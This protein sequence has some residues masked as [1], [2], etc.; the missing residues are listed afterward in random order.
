V[1]PMVAS[2]LTLNRVNELERLKASSFGR[3]VRTEM[4]PR[5][6]AVRLMGDAITVLGA[7][8]R[9]GRLV[10]LGALVVVAGWTLGP[11]QKLASNSYFSTVAPREVAQ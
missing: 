7:W 8:R 4:T 1:V 6:Q 5:M 11:R 3:Y 10:C 2:A 9:S